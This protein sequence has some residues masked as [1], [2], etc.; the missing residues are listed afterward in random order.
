MSS[1]II[2]LFFEFF[3][4]WAESRFG[5]KSTLLPQAGIPL[6]PLGDNDAS[7]WTTTVGRACIERETHTMMTEI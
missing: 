1:G 3:Q 2:R 5:G 6:A 4:V 7:H